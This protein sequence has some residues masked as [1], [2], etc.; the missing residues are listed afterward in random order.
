MKTIV[1]DLA[2]E[3]SFNEIFQSFENTKINMIVLNEEG[4]AGGWPECELTGS[5]EDLRVWLL[6]NYCDENDVDYFLNGE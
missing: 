4:P 1:L 2:F 3:N 5:E 6:E